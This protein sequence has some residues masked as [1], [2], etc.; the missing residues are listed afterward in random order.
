VSLFLVQD[1]VTMGVMGM[2]IALTIVGLRLTQ[3]N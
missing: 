1:L 3:R 2:A